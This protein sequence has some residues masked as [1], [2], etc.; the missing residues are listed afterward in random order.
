[1]TL[2]LRV[3]SILPNHHLSSFLKKVIGSF[4]V[5]SQ[6]RPVTCWAR[7]ELQIPR[8]T[9]SCCGGNSIIC[10]IFT[11]LWVQMD[12]VTR[13]EAHL[14]LSSHQSIIFNKNKICFRSKHD[15]RL[16]LTIIL[17]NPIINHITITEEIWQRI[18]DLCIS[19]KPLCIPELSL[20]SWRSAK[21]QTRS[22]S[23]VLSLLSASADK[24]QRSRNRRDYLIDYRLNICISHKLSFHRM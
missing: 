24:P 9:E 4:K 15:D 11:T 1:M 17:T 12:S 13:D 16:S 18:Q 10:S 5:C 21:A 14:T 3:V 19:S 23:S 8:V 22:V 6:P 20:S 2:R 7:L